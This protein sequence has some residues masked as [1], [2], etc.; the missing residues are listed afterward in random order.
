VSP[1]KIEWA[2][3]LSTNV[4]NTIWLWQAGSTALAIFATMV[5]GLSLVWSKL[6]LDKYYKFSRGKDAELRK[7]VETTSSTT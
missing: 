2:L 1:L 3:L 5:A 4:V 7:Q 6:I